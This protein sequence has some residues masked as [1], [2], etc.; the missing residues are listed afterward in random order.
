MVVVSQVSSSPTG[1][2]SIT[3]SILGA[4]WGGCT[5]SLVN[6][7]DIPSFVNKLRKEYPPYQSLSDEQFS[8]AVFATRPGE[9]AF[10]GLFPD[11]LA[12]A[13]PNSLQFARLNEGKENDIMLI[14]LNISQH[15]IRN[16]ME[17]VYKF[18]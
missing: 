15:T 12:F 17:Y 18:L 8:T 9:G 6:K 13:G 7:A 16:S 1:K 14:N 4:G 5:V 2:Y 10:G 11:V 3:N